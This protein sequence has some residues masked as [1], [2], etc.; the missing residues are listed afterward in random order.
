MN[1]GTWM[2]RLTTVVAAAACVAL[3]A[4]Q[5]GG[6]GRGGFGQR[7]G[8]DGT[9]LNLLG[10]ADV[11]RDMQITDAQKA[12]ITALQEKQRAAFG[13]GR[14]GGGAG[15][16]N[17]DPDAL[18]AE[19][20]KRNAETKKEIA[21]I[22]DEGQVKRLGEIRVQLAGNRAVLDSEAQKALA[23]SEAQIHQVRDLQAKQREAQA[24]LI[25]KMRNQELDRDQMRAAQQKNNEVLGAELG[26]VL[27][28]A[29]RAKLKEMGGTEFKADPPPA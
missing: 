15:G 10:R 26:K 8:M 13:Q 23:L 19:M 21:A 7:G 1:K 18:R 9:G 20:E 6:Q 29:Q 22:L 5:G 4:A 24:A 27:T 12:K 17:F 14:G 3:A 2:V 16:G 25:E 11:Q 28:D